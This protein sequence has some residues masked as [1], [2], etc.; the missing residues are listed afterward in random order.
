MSKDKNISL[1]RLQL[2]YFCSDLSFNYCVIQNCVDY[3]PQL[4]VSLLICCVWVRDIVHMSMQMHITGVYMHVCSWSWRIYSFVV[5]CCG[6]EPAL[7]A[8]KQYP[9][10]IF[11]PGVV[12]QSKLMLRVSQRHHKQRSRRSTSGRQIFL[13]FLTLLFFKLR[14]K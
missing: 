6:R 14:G 4:N 7:P 12:C 8:G 1:I 11:W 2:I 9:G 5:L 3:H 13:T 10:I